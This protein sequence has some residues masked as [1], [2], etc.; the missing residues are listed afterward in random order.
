MILKGPFCFEISLLG[1]PRNYS[2]KDILT[3][4]FSTGR[5][6]DK[7]L[8]ILF[9]AI[10]LITVTLQMKKVGQCHSDT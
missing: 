7:P 6:H 8:C 4:H 9:L 10:T 1:S 2:C 3:E 5:V